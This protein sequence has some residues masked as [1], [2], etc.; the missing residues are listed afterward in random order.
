MRAGAA[1][2]AALLA[3]AAAAQEPPPPGRIESFPRAENP[4]A[5]QSERDERKLPKD[6]TAADR[7]ERESV[8]DSSGRLRTQ[9]DQ[10]NQLPGLRTDRL[11]Q[12]QSPGY[13]VGPGVRIIRRP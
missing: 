6:T 12:N 1:M 11:R 4:A 8:F 7:R 3:S 2:I 5:P 10:V 9:Q 13:S